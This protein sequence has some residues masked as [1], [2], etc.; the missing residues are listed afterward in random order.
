MKN[1]AFSA[2]L[3]TG[4]TVASLFLTSPVFAQ[5]VNPPGRKNTTPT[6][7]VTPTPTPRPVR[8]AVTFSQTRL[9]NG[10]LEACQAH[11]AV[12]KTRLKSLLRFSQNM[13][14]VFDKIS[15]RVQT[16]YKDHVL[17]EGK[18]VENYDALISDIQTKQAKVQD[19]LKTAQNDA[20][21]FDCT[22]I[23]PRTHLTQFRLDMQEVKTSL[24]E[25]RTSIKNLIVA[26]RGVAAEGA[27]PSG[28]P[29][30]TPAQ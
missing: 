21:S 7:T 12:L 22:G 18:T 9:A 19:D 2:A 26:V 30:A 1:N 15:T 29:T 8:A 4:L 28:T 25:Y 5:R 20:D 10:P 3:V 14:D 24:K 13:L 23:D 16:F 17:A 27:T 11:E 6:V